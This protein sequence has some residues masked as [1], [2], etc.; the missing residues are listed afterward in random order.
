MQNYAD[1]AHLQN[2][3]QYMLQ[4]N[5]ICTAQY[6]HCSLLLQLSSADIVMSTAN[7]LCTYILYF[8]ELQKTLKENWNSYFNDN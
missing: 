7:N 3:A 4:I 5:K 8:N 6:Q 1:L 2:A